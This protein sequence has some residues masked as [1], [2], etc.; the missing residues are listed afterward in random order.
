M[1]N[2][3]VTTETQLDHID[4]QSVKGYDRLAPWYR[5]IETLAFG[6]ALMRARTSLASRLNCPERILVLG[7]GDGRLLAEL[8][9]LYPQA[10]FVSVDQSPKMLQRQQT[11]AASIDADDRVEFVRADIMDWPLARREFDV[12]VAA[13]FLDCFEPATLSKLLPRLLDSVRENGCL[14]YVDFVVPPKPLPAFYAKIMLSVMHRFF[15]WQT[16]LRNASLVDVPE[17]LNRLSWT[18]A[19][20]SDQHFGMMTARIYQRSTHEHGR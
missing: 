18:V 1:N 8:L 20:Q 7:D 9:T 12:V 5:G 6:R 15:A 11:R 19:N 14:Y 17:M 13:F 10:G 2:R 3:A 4:H 16:G